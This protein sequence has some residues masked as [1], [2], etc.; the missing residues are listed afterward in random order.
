MFKKTLTP[1]EA[2]NKI[3]HYC[4]YQERCH[5]EVKEKLYSYGLYKMQVEN[6]LSNLI[7]NNYLNE[8]RF[9]I[10]FAGGKFRMKQWGKKKIAYELQQKRV[11]SYC[12][13]IGL[14]Q[15]DD[16]SYHQTLETLLAGKWQHLHG[17]HYITRQAKAYAY[18]LQKGYE[19]ALINAALAA[20]KSSDT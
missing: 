6:I 4:A 13:K 5:H 8:E 19:P 12:I 16:E 1:E 17:Q 15:I 3:K 20:I 14:K 2:L 7:E 9:A 11:S 18:L 10:Q